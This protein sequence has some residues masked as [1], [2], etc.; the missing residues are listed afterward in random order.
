[1]RKDAWLYVLLAVKK[2]KEEMEVSTTRKDRSSSGFTIENSGR[3]EEKEEKE[4][5]KVKRR[6][7]VQPKDGVQFHQDKSRRASK[8]NKQQH[9]YDEAEKPG[10][11]VMCQE[12]FFLQLCSC[13]CLCF[14]ARKEQKSRGRLR[15]EHTEKE[16]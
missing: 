8:K 1:M 7:Q 15:P 5:K 3:E 4:K 16:S 13:L 10:W 6:S 11:K 14:C 12:V 2:R 9:V